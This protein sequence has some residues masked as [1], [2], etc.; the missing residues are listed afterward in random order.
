MT[1]LE[2]AWERGREV[3]DGSGDSCGLQR[4]LTFGL[5]VDVLGV[6]LLG[7]L[8]HAEGC[9]VGVDSVQHVGVLVASKPL[10]FPVESQRLLTRQ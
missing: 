2:I 1:L 10:I 6:L 7:M 9:T 5:C 3:G 8:C 4:L